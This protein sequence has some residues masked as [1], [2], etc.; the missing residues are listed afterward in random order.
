[1]ISQL[2]MLNLEL[3]AQL[4]ADISQD[5]HIEVSTLCPKADFIF[6]ELLFDL[7]YPFEQVVHDYINRLAWCLYAV[8]AE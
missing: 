3:D 6:T 1:M 7:V 8:I 5:S 2:G 4:P